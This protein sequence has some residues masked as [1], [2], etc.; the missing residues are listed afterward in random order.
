MNC[1]PCN[2]SNLLEYHDYKD[3]DVI[4]CVHNNQK[5]TL[6]DLKTILQELGQLEFRSNRYQISSSLTGAIIAGD[7]WWLHFT[8]DS[9]EDL[10]WVYHQHPEK[11]WI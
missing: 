1:H 5:C 6:A 4:F 9:C 3:E 7:D 11:K 2:I 8:C 10:E